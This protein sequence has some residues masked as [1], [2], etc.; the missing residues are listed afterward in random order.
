MK[1]YSLAD[2]Q[3][4]RDLESGERFLNV[5]RICGSESIVA[6]LVGEDVVTVWSN[7][8]EMGRL[9]SFDV[10]D[11]DGFEDC[12]VGDIKVTGN[13]VILFLDDGS[14]TKQLVVLHKGV[15]EHNWE[16]KILEPF[17]MSSLLAVDKEWFA[18][19]GRD[20]SRS[21]I[22]KVNLWE[23]ELLKR[24]IELPEVSAVYVRYVV[25]ESPFF[26]V[27]GT[28][29]SGGSRIQVFQLVADNLMEDLNSAPPL[30][31]TVQFPGLYARKLLCT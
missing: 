29:R 4:V 27:G 28:N 24:D 19:V 21:D 5:L 2:G 12:W 18:V 10:R 9:H 7:K 26:V 25:L 3:W 8:E 23:E 16:T 13:K 22:V 11:H 1:V 20:E 14:S 6:A 31:K 30:V 15:T 17:T